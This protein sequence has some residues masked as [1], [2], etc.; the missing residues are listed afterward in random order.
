MEPRS[1]PSPSPPSPSL[2]LPSQGSQPGLGFEPTLAGGAFF[3]ALA[4]VVNFHGLVSLE[5]CYRERLRFG[6]Q[7]LLEGPVS[8]RIGPGQV[9]AHSQTAVVVVAYA[10]YAVDSGGL[11][12]VLGAGVELLTGRGEGFSEVQERTDWELALVAGLRWRQRLRGPL[13][14]VAVLEARGRLHQQRVVVDG[15]AQTMALAPVS[16]SLVL[17]LMYRWK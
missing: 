16:P 12:L 3:D 4:G 17:G 15:V 10:P 13:F 7:L 14:G 9:S 1:P 2:S 6:L 5:G 8:K 11:D